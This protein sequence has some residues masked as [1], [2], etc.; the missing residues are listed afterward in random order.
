MTDR[1]VLLDALLTAPSMAA[2]VSPE[3]AA[4]LLAALGA[5]QT[6]LVARV[7]AR[8]PKDTG[9][10]TRSPLDRLLKPQEAASRL[11]VKIRWLYDHASKLPFTRRLSRKALRFSERGLDEYMRKKRP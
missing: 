9:A 5:I 8:P 4:G 11:G 1:A 2:E 10:E 6:S 3:E 7:L